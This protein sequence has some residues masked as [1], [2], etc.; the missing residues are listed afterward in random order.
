MYLIG[1]DEVGRG[2]LA[3]PV[4][5]AAVMIAKGM[6]FPKGLRDSKRLSEKQ[7]SEWLLYIKNNP[8]IFCASAVVSPAVIDRINI[9]QAANLAALRALSKFLRPIGRKI[10]IQLD[11]GLYLKNKD[12][13]KNFNA[14]TV[15]KGDE[16]INAIKLASIV[17]KVKRDKMMKRLGNIFPEYCF[18]IH[19]GYA[20]KL[21][22]E[23][24][25]KNG[26]CEWHRRSF[27]KRI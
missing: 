20:T 27:C 25:K 19:K 26:L 7:R 4:V 1:I 12:Y 23:A 22:R 10:K 8:K 11:G 2:C 5:V 6:K 15:I 13:Q 21:H 18:E 16:K 9:S 24:I 14:E 17:A 3:G